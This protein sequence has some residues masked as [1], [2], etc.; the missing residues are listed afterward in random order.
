MSLGEHDEERLSRILHAKPHERLG[1]E[2]PPGGYAPP[3]GFYRV[4]ESPTAD[5]LFLRLADDGTVWGLSFY[6]GSWA[7]RTLGQSFDEF[8]RRNPLAVLA[9]DVDRTD[10]PR[11]AAPAPDP[12]LDS[13]IDSNIDIPLDRIAREF[14]KRAGRAFGLGDDAAAN[15]L[16][17][18]CKRIEALDAEMNPLRG[19]T[20]DR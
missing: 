9:Q 5:P 12:L 11:P 3:P 14:R 4:A 19:Y 20:E 18:L 16:R 2:P 1:F 13:N 7:Y 17:D 10:N 8:K 15:K 6:E